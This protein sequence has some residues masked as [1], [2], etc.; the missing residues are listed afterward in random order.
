[1]ASKFDAANLNNCQDI[2]LRSIEYV[3]NFSVDF[4]GT[5]LA[6]EALKWD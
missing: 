4:P 6:S 1:M 3:R 2:E 5:D